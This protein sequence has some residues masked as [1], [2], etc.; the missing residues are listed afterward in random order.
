MFLFMITDEG[1]HLVSTYDVSPA[2]LWFVI[3]AHS[4]P[5]LLASGIRSTFD[6]LPY[7]FRITVWLSVG[8]EHLT[9]IVK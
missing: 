4:L 2:H 5:P 7:S 8:L 3:S 1:T 6:R 9:L